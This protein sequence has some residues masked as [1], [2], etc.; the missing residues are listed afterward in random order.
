MNQTANTEDGWMSLIW[1]FSRSCSQS[2]H[3]TCFPFHPFTGYPHVHRSTEAHS[4]SREGSDRNDD[5][6]E[7]KGNYNHLWFWCVWHH[8]RSSHT[9]GRMTNHVPL[10]SNAKPHIKEKFCF[11]RLYLCIWRTL[12]AK[13][14]HITFKP[15]DL[16]IPWVSNLLTYHCRHHVLDKLSK[17]PAASVSQRKN[18]VF[19]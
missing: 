9:D 12:L 1:L 4:K 11:T 13:A 5:A 10:N 3:I 6:I 2:A 14:T 7:N 15:L 8:C 19:P 18:K 17:Q 16:C